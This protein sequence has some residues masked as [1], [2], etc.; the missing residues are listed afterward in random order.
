MLLQLIAQH[1]EM[2][3]PILRN[4]PTWV[5]GLL[6]TLLALGMS[7]VR[8]RNVSA[9]RMA[10]IP[11]AMTG[12]SLWGTISAFGSSPQFGYVLL[13]WA[14]SMALMAGLIGTQAAPRGA[15]YIAATRSFNVPGSWLPLALILGIF[16]TK[17]IVGVE[18]A[19]KPTLA[20]D[21]QYTLI[22]GAL[23]GLFSGS[24]TGRAARLWRLALKPS[25]VAPAPALTA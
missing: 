10:L 11:V 16:M 22:V 24:F 5:W 7:H 17:Y 8:T 6:A 3:M 18:L 2:I 13:V 20:Q 1:P 9:T 21:G 19:M 23:Y 12:L 4:T 25:A 14:A 15:R